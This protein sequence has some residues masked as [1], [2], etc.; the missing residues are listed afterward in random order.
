MARLSVDVCWNRSS[1]QCRPNSP[2]LSLCDQSSCLIRSPSLLEQISALSSRS[3]LLR[4]YPHRHSLSGP[5]LKRFKMLYCITAPSRMGSRSIAP[6]RHRRR[7]TRTRPRPLTARRSPL[8]SSSNPLSP[9]SSR[10]RRRNARL[11]QLRLHRSRFYV[12]V[13]TSCPRM[14]LL[15]DQ[16]EARHA[17]R[18]ALL[19]TL[20]HE[21]RAAAIGRLNFKLAGHDKIVDKAK[22]QESSRDDDQGLVDVL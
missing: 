12:I 22:R 20:R 15:Q 21:Q 8:A 1:S 2:K 18:T 5:Y 19:D 7:L 16:Q 3:P 13:N 4:R 10:R 11:R 9:P 14:E 6:P 17:G